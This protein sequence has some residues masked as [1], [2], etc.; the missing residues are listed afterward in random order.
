MLCHISNLAHFLSC[1][2]NVE[3]TWTQVP[4]ETSKGRQYSIILWRSFPVTYSRKAVEDKT[5]WP[6]VLS[7]KAMNKYCTNAA[8]GTCFKMF[9]LFSVI[10]R[11]HPLRQPNKKHWDAQQEVVGR[12]EV[13]LY[14]L[15][16]IKPVRKQEI[17]C[18]D[19]SS[20]VFTLFWLYMLQ[21]SNWESVQQS[22]SVT[23]F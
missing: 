9:R 10:W 14:V 1:G 21:L 6:E 15:R 3:Y 23:Q 18:L 8:K 16:C 13:F 17:K 11:A 22:S 19:N 2:T 4:L 5:Q 7:T 20:S 12:W